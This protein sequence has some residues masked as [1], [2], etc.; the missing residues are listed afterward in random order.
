M[1]AWIALSLSLL[2]APAASIMITKQREPSTYFWPEPRGRAESYSVSPYAAPRNLTGSLAWSWFNGGPEGKYSNS[3]HSGLVIDDKKNIYLSS[4]DGI[5][6]FTSDGDLLWHAS[7]MTW[8]IPTLYEGAVYVTTNSGTLVVLSMETGKQL[9][10]KKYT[11][12]LGT[13]ISGVGVHNGV[14]VCESHGGP[15]GGAFGVAGMNASNGDLLWDV[16][17]DDQ[18]WNFMPMFT[19]HDTFVFQDKKGGAYHYGLKDGKRIW[20]S[21]YAASSNSDF[22]DGLT[23]L[24]GDKVYTVHSDGTC[25]Q[26]NQ[27]A[28]LRAY[29][30]SSGQEAWMQAFP[31]P[32]NS[33]AAVGHLGKGVGLSENL[34]VVM[35]IGAQP[36]G[37]LNVYGSSIGAFD[38]NT[39]APIWE[40][41]FPAYVNSFVAGDKERMKHGTLCLPNPYGSPSIDG[42]G[43]VYTGHF[44]GFIYA[45]R[46]DNGDNIIQDSEVSKFDTGAGFSH[47][48]VALAPG[49]LAIPSCDG[50]YVFKE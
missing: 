43:T 6:K 13:D 27:A 49:M 25:C 3:A 35:P 40:W 17:T 20:K 45:I 2:V 30:L 38:A 4:T 12:N 8:R 16:P 22:T 7:M 29:D 36:A 42:S 41:N 11:D 9:W 44:N 31:H 23:M 10:S 26:A 1:T 48:G 50:L 24:A 46:D 33:Q 32:A 39:G 28:N 19:D 15:D 21:G 5:R 18:L 37:Q 34:A 14:V 47:G